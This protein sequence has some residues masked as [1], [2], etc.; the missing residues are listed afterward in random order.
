MTR[1]ITVALVV[2]HNNDDIRSFRECDTATREGDKRCEISDHV[3]CQSIVR[4]TVFSTVEITDSM[5]T[6]E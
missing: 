6:I 4:G 2:R 5:G 1:E 3:F